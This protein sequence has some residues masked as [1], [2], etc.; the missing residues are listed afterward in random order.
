[1]NSQPTEVQESTSSESPQSPYQDMAARVRLHTWTCPKQLKRPPK[2][3][4]K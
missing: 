4:T 3:Y 1:M 2:H